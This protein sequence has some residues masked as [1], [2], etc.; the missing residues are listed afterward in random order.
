MR[1]DPAPQ[2]GFTLLELVIVLGVLAVI[3]VVSLPSLDATQPYKLDVA[4]TALADSIRFARV[5]AMRMARPY[6][7]NIEP[8]PKRVRVFRGSGSSLPPTP[9][10]DVIDPIS[11]RLFDLDLDDQSTTEG[12]SFAAAPSWSGACSKPELLGFDAAGTPRCGDPWS[13]V[14]TTST[15]TL[16]H[17][18]RT[19]SI[20]IDGETGRVRVQ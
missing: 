12:V 6:G 7:V 2:L 5:E 3:A 18:G 1:C 20:V 16:S 11:K 8:G 10:Y 4:A 13:V 15:L 14:L 19:R 17:A 9:V